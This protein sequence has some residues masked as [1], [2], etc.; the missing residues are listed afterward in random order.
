MKIGIGRVSVAAI[1]EGCV[2]VLRCIPQGRLYTWSMIRKSANV[3]ST[4]MT[5][6]GLPLSRLISVYELWRFLTAYRRTSLMHAGC[7]MREHSALGIQHSAKPR[8]F[9]AVQPSEK[10]R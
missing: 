2:I 7:Q 6:I 5:V 3:A 10:P 9:F 4:R 8:V 1:S